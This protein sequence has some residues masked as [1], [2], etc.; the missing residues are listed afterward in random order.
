[1]DELCFILVKIFIPY[2]YILGKK[3]GREKAVPDRYAGMSSE[4]LFYFNIRCGFT[5]AA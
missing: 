1:M 2:P 4:Y 5:L 3:G